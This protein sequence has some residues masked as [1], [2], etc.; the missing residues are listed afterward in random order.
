MCSS[1]QWTNDLMPVYRSSFTQISDEKAGL[2]GCASLEPK[3]F[4]RISRLLDHCDRTFRAGRKQHNH[5]SL[6]HCV[7]KITLD[8]MTTAVQLLRTYCSSLR[9]AWQPIAHLYCA[10]MRPET[11]SDLLSILRLY[12]MRAELMPPL[13]WR[14][15]KFCLKLVAAS[16]RRVSMA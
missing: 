9:A 8:K 13:A 5:R 12:P 6:G 10:I 7:H 2:I 14:A 1:G 16:C 15:D 3:Q 4:Q 11:S